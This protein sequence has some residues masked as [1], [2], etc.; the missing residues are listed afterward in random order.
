[1]RLFHTGAQRASSRR[2]STGSHLVRQA[3]DAPTQDRVSAFGVQKIR[4]ASSQRGRH[5]TSEIEGAWENLAI[6]PR[7]RDED[8]HEDRPLLN[9]YGAI[10][11]NGTPVA[12]RGRKATGLTEPAG[13]PKGRST[14]FWDGNRWVSDGPE[15]Q[16]VQTSPISAGSRVRAWVATLPIIALIPAL[17]IPLLAFAS[18]LPTLSVSGVVA[19]AATITIGGDNFPS[20]DWFDIRWDGVPATSARSDADGQFSVTYTVPAAATSGPHELAAFERAPGKSPS[21]GSAAEPGAIAVLVVLVEQLTVSPEPT[22][23]TAPID[24]PPPVDSPTPTPDTSASAPAPDPT[25]TALPSPTLAPSAAALVIGS[26]T[27]TNVTQTDATITWTVSAPATGQVEYGLSEALGSVSTLEASF[28]YTT[29]IQLLSGLAAGSAYYYRVRSVDAAGNVVVSD[30]QTFTTLALTDPTPTPV[31]TLTPTPDPTPAP[32]TAPTPDPT[33]APTP[34]PTTAPTPAPT[35]TPTPAA[36]PTPTPSSG[37]V[38]VPS[39]I[40]ASGASDASAALNA[41]VKSVPDGSTILFKAG[42]IYRMDHALRVS[43]RHDLV[44]DG[45]NA[46]L[47][48]NGSASQPGDSPLA[49]WNYNAGITVR[50]LNIVGNNT[51]P[52]VYHPGAEDQMGILI[53]GGS[54]Y[55]I[56]NVHIRNPWGECLFIGGTG[57]PS[58]WADSIR[59]HD[60]TCTGAG[61]MGVAPVA[62]SHVVIERVTF[63]LVAWAVL[64]VEPYGSDEG[65]AYITFRD[66]TV[67]RPGAMVPSF[68]SAGGT[69]G[70]NVHDITITGNTV[71]GGTLRTDISVARRKNI[72]F[73]NNTSSVAAS[74]PVLTFA[75]VDG[76]V[77]TGNVQPLKS[78]SSASFSDCTG[79]TYT[80]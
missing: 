10:P 72:V 45:Q 31:P 18:T 59:F 44:F 51:Q 61:R 19:P 22:L 12:R 60:S 14:M 25:A 2:T 8:P 3:L 65:A 76:L 24:P 50:N 63:D 34:A 47:R 64:D 30:L 37:A 26:V 43:G 68:V 75:H 57:T 36:T 23:T 16:R 20:R 40:D 78:G 55:D 52:G 79:V 33:P 80:N 7:R 39:T 56:S 42:G 73:T 15:T 35:P 70:T 28:T 67:L 21:R 54:G 38:Q 17:L 46:T 29:H 6:A 13:L 9:T 4:V 27:A 5:D 49:F 58:V 74:G 41:F 32:T 71:T 77:V 53:Y 69:T 1:L 66:N 48:A 11:R 62:A